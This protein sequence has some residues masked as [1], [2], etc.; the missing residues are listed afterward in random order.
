MLD[1]DHMSQSDVTRIDYR[2]GRSIA[3]IA[4]GDLHVKWSQS[5]VTII[6]HRYMQLNITCYSHC[7]KSKTC[8]RQTEN[9]VIRQMTT[10]EWHITRNDISPVML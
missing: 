6:V 1:E 2:Q 3:D 9:F 5:A 8:H 10:T 4:V 7:R